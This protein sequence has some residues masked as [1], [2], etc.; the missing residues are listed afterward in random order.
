MK[1]FYGILLALSALY[2]ALTGIGLIFPQQFPQTRFQLAHFQLIK[3][4]YIV[5]EQDQTAAISAIGFNGW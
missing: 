4:D 1:N 3:N 2:L 5:D